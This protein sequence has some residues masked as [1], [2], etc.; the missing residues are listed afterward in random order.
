MHP[1]RA[2]LVRVSGLTAMAV[3]DNDN[4][5]PSVQ[6]V[7]GVRNRI[8]R[9]QAPLSQQRRP[10]PCAGLCAAS[11]YNPPAK[12]I[13]SRGLPHANSHH[14][15]NPMDLALARLAYLTLALPGHAAAIP[16]RDD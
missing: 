16:D 7:V 15:R 6:L 12:P 2:E 10:D 3:N 4:F 9:R 1:I 11:G 14:I 5:E 8:E 13:L